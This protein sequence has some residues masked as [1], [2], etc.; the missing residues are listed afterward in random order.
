MSLLM[1]SSDL[2]CESVQIRFW[3][4][5]CSLPKEDTWGR[6]SVL[7]LACKDCSGNVAFDGQDKDTPIA[8][9]G[10]HVDAGY[11]AKE[12]SSLVHFANK[13][14]EVSALS[15]YLKAG[16]RV[17]LKMLPETWRASSRSW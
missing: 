17:V 3:Q 5:S 10:F 15:E 9:H 1:E 7:D 16:S 14:G 6:Q 13:L 4:G 12:S 2:S 8:D 11:D